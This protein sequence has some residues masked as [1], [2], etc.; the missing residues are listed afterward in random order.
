MNALRRVTWT[1][2]APVRALL[3]GG[4]RLYRLTLSGWLGGQCRFHPTCSHYAEDAIRQHGALRGSVMAS[5]RI[6]RCNPF[7]AGGIDL[8][9]PGRER[10]TKAQSRKYDGVLHEA[11]APA[12]RA[13]ARSL[14]GPGGEAPA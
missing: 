8:V 2:G 9:P 6:M 11:M 10:H 7:G 13:D 5:W 4:I 12:D 3:I 1:L 14:A